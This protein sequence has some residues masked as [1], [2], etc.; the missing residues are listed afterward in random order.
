MAE[1]RQ[2]DAKKLC[3]MTGGI[4]REFVRKWLRTHDRISF[5]MKLEFPG[6]GEWFIKEQGLCIC[7]TV[8]KCEKRVIK[9]EIYETYKG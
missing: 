4:R 6:H 7:L 8:G 5:V 1:I 9:F 3:Q 2:I